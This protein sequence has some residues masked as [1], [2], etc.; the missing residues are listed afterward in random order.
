MHYFMCN[1]IHRR[2][3]DGV[4][5]NANA[6]R[7]QVN[8]FL[9]HFCQSRDL[10]LPGKVDGSNLLMRETMESV[11]AAGN[12]YR[13]PPEIPQKIERKIVRPRYQRDRR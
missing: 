11:R 2:A 6:V 4:H 3:A 13:F 1:Q 9:T 5:W 7:M 12:D 8:I 10:P